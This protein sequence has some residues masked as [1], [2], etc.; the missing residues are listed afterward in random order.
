MDFLRGIEGCSLFDGEGSE[1]SM[2]YGRENEVW[3]NVL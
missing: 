3:K 1:K 2:E